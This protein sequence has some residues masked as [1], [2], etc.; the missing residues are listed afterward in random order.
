MGLTSGEERHILSLSTPKLICEISLVMN[1]YKINRN[2]ANKSAFRSSEH[3]GRFHA[4]NDPLL[5][6]HQNMK[7]TRV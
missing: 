2:V 1:M 4:V 5:T 3:R 6:R 7:L